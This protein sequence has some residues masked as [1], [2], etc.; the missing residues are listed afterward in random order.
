MN[1]HEHYRLS[2]SQQAIL[3]WLRKA[4][5]VD[6]AGQCVRRTRGV[7]GYLNDLRFMEYIDWADPL[8][9]STAVTL[10]DAGRRFLEREFAAAP[11]DFDQ[12]AQIAVPIFGAKDLAF[13]KELIFVV[14]PFAEEFDAVFDAVRCAVEV[15]CQKRCRRADDLFRAQPIIHTVWEG[16]NK[17]SVVI[18][19]LSGKNANVFYELGISHTLGKDVVLI[20]RTDSDI[21]FDL[22]QH[23]YHIYQASADGLERLCEA[24]AIAV[25]QIHLARRES[26]G[27][28]V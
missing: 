2:A 27:W 4:G 13:D 24:L 22:R 23:P 28:L 25:S 1:I 15:R 10:T 12:R 20:A 3:I 18:A 21:P 5:G 9:A 6:N 7:F 14:M 8:K 16:I 17:A 19:D 11:D 26:H